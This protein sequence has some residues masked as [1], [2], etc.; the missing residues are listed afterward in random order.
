MGASFKQQLRRPGR[1]K[2]GLYAQGEML[3]RYD[4]QVSLHPTRKDKWGIPQLHIDC[5]FSEN[6]TLMM[7]DAAE[8]GEKMLK[9]AGLSEVQSRVTR[10]PPGLAIHEL[11]TAR[12]G[13]D[14]KTSV[15]NGANQCHD[16]DNLFVTDGASFCS[17]AVQNPSLTIMALTARAADFAANELKNGKF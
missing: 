2:F 9:A 13:R 6:E 12:M 16:I 4:N 11:G 7:A 5:E 17:T 14:K 15:L 3:P 10:K 8:Q 1:W